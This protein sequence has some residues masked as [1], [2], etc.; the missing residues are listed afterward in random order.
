[1]SFEDRSK[2][3][4]WRRLKK[5][6]TRGKIAPRTTKRKN[7]KSFPSN[8]GPKL[9]FGKNNPW[10][11]PKRITKYVIS[12]ISKVGLWPEMAENRTVYYQ[13]VRLVLK[14]SQLFFYLMQTK[15]HDF[16]SKKHSH[17]KKIAFFF[18]F[19]FL[20][21]GVNLNAHII[22]RSLRLVCMVNPKL[23]SDW[24]LTFFTNSIMI[25][26]VSLPYSN[27]PKMFQSS[28]HILVCQTYWKEK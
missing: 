20:G 28:W 5:V 3:G 7:Y 23:L 9:N 11:F 17:L 24:I 4:A 13:K 6:G 19:F 8:F 2:C 1:M 16:I 10:T 21:G 14:S 22:P 12:E 15:I 26:K 18:F 25:I 27:I